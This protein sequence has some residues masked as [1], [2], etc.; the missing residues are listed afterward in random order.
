MDGWKMRVPF[1]SKPIFR[2]YVKFLGCIRI[3]INQ[4][5]PI[6]CLFF[7]SGQEATPPILCIAGSFL[8]KISREVTTL[9]RQQQPLGEGRFSMFGICL[10]G[11]G[12]IHIPLKCVHFEDDD[13]PN[14]PFGGIPV[15]FLE[16]MFFFSHIFVSLSTYPGPSTKLSTKFHTLKIKF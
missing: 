15:N 8:R 1:W 6:G 2:D 11:N 3:P 7:R 5:Q 14:F 16:G 12:Y 9:A 4:P 10:L 13:F